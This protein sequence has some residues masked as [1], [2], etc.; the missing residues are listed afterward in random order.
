LGLSL[1]SRRRRNMS[2]GKRVEFLI[3]KFVERFW[4]AVIPIPMDLIETTYPT[5]WL[6]RSNVCLA[7]DSDAMIPTKVYVPYQIVV[8][9]LLAM[10]ESVLAIESRVVHQTISI[11]QF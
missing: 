6:L 9:S 5:M 3:L 4:R 8:I 1:F 11:G 10:G 2:R 7:E